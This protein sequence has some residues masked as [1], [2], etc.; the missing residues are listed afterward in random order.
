MAVTRGSTATLLA[1]AEVTSG[2]T[3]TTPAMLELPYVNWNPQS[4]ITVMTSE[5]IRSHPYD[6]KLL[7][8]RFAHTIG[9][10]FEMQNGVHDMLYESMF[11]GAFTA[12]A[13]AF[14]DALKTMTIEERVGG[15]SSL[16]NQF[17]GAYLNKMTIT[18]AGSDTAPVKVTSS[19]MA[20]VGTLDAAATIA[21]S[22]VAAANVDPFIFA[23]ATLTTN[24]GATAVASGTINLER[25]VDPLML[26]GSRIERENIPGAVKA[27]M[28][29]TVPY[30]TNAQSTLVKN[31]TDAALIFNF[32]SKG[33]TEFRRLTFPKTKFISL[34]RPINSRGGRMQEINVQAYYDSTSGTICTMTTQ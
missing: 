7:D 12:K 24:A 17:T 22:V 5:Q 30:D 15:G 9:L 20:R 33:G 14:A 18:A 1:I 10:D 13:L 11:G 31:F 16:F 4:A 25:Q 34:G 28:S 29:L 19:G 32:A 3:P 6:D 21:G 27:T 8:G 23:D 2:V 26:W